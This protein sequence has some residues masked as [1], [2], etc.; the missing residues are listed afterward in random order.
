MTISDPDLR[1]YLKSV[2]NLGPYKSYIFSKF[3]F[4]NPTQTY[5]LQGSVGKLNYVLCKMFHIID[6]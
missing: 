3:Y 1:L 2:H 5:F 6:M 4:S